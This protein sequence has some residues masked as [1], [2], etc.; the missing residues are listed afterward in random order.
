MQEM[1][2]VENKT[3]NR[4]CQSGKKI[5]ASRR[6]LVRMEEEGNNQHEGGNK[7]GKLNSNKAGNSGM[8]DAGSSRGEKKKSFRFR[9][10][11]KLGKVWK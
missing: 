6:S 10:Q 9:L 2:E 4:S 3:E 7:E 5:Q 8:G 11:G 1:K